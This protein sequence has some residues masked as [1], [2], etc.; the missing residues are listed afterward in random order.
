MFTFGVTC[1]LGFVCLGFAGTP[2]RVAIQLTLRM[3]DWRMISR[4]LGFKRHVQCFDIYQKGWLR[5]S[6]GPISQA[7]DSRCPHSRD[8]NS[9]RFLG[10]LL[11]GMNRA[12]IRWLTIKNCF[13]RLIELVGWKFGNLFN[14]SS[15]CA[16]SEL[17]ESV[18]LLLPWWLKRQPGD[19]AV[20]L[21]QHARLEL[22]WC[23]H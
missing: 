3:N 21:P 2:S 14:E 9:V 17:E 4:L 6:N 22:S 5:R 20:S 18:L 10:A 23:L 16:A 8:W 13:M 11:D 15:R 19:T 1:G 7:P 12:R